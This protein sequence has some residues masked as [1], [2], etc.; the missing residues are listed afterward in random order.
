M[1]KKTHHVVP[2]PT[3]GWSVRKG[4]AARASKLFATKKEAESYG[5]KLSV[6]EGSELVI[7]RSDGTIQRKDSHGRDPLPP[8]DAR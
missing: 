7:H 4:G 6:R 8:R 1:A 5:R 3:G 2:A